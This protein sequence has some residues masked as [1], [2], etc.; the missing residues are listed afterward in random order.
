MKLDRKKILGDAMHHYGGHFSGSHSYSMSVEC[1]DLADVW[2]N[3][4]QE[5]FGA[6][7]AKSPREMRK[8]LRKYVRSNVSYSDHK[9]TFIPA[10]IWVAIAQAIISWIVGKIIDNV[11]EQREEGRYLTVNPDST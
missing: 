1:V 7:M 4:Y 5:D 11:L 3:N 6:L 10:F 9:A 2:L 8:E